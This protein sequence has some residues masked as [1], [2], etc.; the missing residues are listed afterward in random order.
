MKPLYDRSDRRIRSA[1][2]EREK[3]R[4]T[5]SDQVGLLSHRLGREKEGFARAMEA[6]ATQEGDDGERLLP[7]RVPD[8]DIQLRIKGVTIYT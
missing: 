4:K 8:T 7:A 3:A 6:A 5:I 1:E 2:A